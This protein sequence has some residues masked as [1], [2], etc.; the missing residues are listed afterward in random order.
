M[1]P[2]HQSHFHTLPHDLLEQ[3]LEQFRFQKPSVPVLGKCG[4]M[5]NLLIEAQAGEPAPR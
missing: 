3:L 4:V 1:R 5:R 2:L